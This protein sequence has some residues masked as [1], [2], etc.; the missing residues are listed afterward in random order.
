[1]LVFVVMYGLFRMQEHEGNT[2]VVFDVNSS[3]PCA[4]YSD[5][6]QSLSTVHFALPN[7]SLFLAGRQMENGVKHT[8]APLVVMYTSRQYSIETETGI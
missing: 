3:T 6:P 2:V 5:F 1:M 8:Y 7:T 4:V